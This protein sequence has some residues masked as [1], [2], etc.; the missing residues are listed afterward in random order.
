[1]TTRAATYNFV[2]EQGADFR[3]RVRWRVNGVLQNLT[4]FTAAMQVRSTFDSP[5]VLLSLTTENGRLVLGGTGGYVDII[6][7]GALTRAQFFTDA[8]YDLFVYGPSLVSSKRLLK[9]TL[10]LDP[11]VTRV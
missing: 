5:D 6:V 11:R 2:M 10:T 8:V 4:N 7:P 9:G 1:M 3:K